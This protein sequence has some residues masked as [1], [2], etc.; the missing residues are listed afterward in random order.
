MGSPFEQAKA[1]YWRPIGQV[2]SIKT[3]S[4]SHLLPELLA[5]R[6]LKLLN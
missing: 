1:S 2:S 6:T 5:I 4:L 3:L